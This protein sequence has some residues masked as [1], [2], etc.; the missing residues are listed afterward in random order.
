MP[1]KSARIHATCFKMGKRHLNK[2]FPPLPLPEQRNHPVYTRQR[3]TTATRLPARS[4][5]KEA[6]YQNHRVN[7]EHVPSSHVTGYLQKPTEEIVHALYAHFVTTPPE[8]ARH[9]V[10]RPRCRHVAQFADILHCQT[11]L[12]DRVTSCSVLPLPRHAVTPSDERAAGQPRRAV[13]PCSSFRGTPIF[14]ARYGYQAQMR[15]YLRHMPLFLRYARPAA[16]ARMPSPPQYQP[17]FAQ[18]SKHASCSP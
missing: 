9:L 4:Q 12:T 5:N 11:R 10:L 17:L 1:D 6:S 7:E 13:E 3:H 14:N 2:Q 16:H 18:V 8:V 15:R